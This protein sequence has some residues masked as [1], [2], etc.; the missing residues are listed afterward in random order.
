MQRESQLAGSGAFAI[1]ELQYHWPWCLPCLMP[2]GNPL[3]ISRWVLLHPLALAAPACAFALLPGVSRCTVQAP[4][5]P[6][7]AHSHC[8]REGFATYLARKKKPLHC[9]CFCC[10][11]SSWHT[12][13]T[14]PQAGIVTILGSKSSWA[15]VS[16]S[17]MMPIP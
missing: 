5:S 17:T 11:I 13:H 12:K 4:P 9:R 7:L 8:K 2:S 16:A 10:R 15:L 3:A 1:L 6:I 14:T